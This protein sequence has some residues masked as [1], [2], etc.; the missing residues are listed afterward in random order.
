MAKELSRELHWFMQTLK[1]DFGV[2]VI[3]DEIGVEAVELGLEEVEDFFVPIEIFDDLP[4]TLLYELMIVDDELA[5]VWVGAI[6]FSP[7]SPDWCLQVIT[8]NDELVFRNEPPS[9][10]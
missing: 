4:E 10:T 8:K 9:P 1:N 5:N 2:E 3:V 6:A 7:N